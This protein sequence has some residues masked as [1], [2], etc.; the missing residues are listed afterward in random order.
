M[1]ARVPGSRSSGKQVRRSGASGAVGTL[2]ER[3]FGKVWVIL[4]SLAT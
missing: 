1:G 4:W 2:R 3:S